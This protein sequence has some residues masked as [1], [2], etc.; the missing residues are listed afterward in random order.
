MI[1]EIFIFPKRFCEE[2]AL[3]VFML[4]I[5]FAFMTVFCRFRD[6]R[7]GSDGTGVPPARQF[8]SSAVRCHGPRR[9]TDERPGLTAWTISI[10]ICTESVLSERERRMGTVGAVSR[11]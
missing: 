8:G 2:S 10:G 1:A 3:N 7:G 6:G 11:G 4:K 9:P 5:V